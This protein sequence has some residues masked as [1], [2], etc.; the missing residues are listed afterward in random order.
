M[1][2]VVCGGRFR[3][4]KGD[5]FCCPGCTVERYGA[6]QESRTVRKPGLAYNEFPPGY[7]EAA[8]PTGERES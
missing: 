4:F 6:D 8:P 2:C 5:P 3:T 7:G 1:A